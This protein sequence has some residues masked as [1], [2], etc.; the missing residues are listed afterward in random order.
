MI[1][2]PRLPHILNIANGFIDRPH[3]ITAKTADETSYKYTRR[4]SLAVVM[5]LHMGHSFVAPRQRSQHARQHVCQQPVLT[6]GSVYA[7]RQIRHCVE[8]AD[9]PCDSYSHRLRQDF[10]W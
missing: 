2:P 5:R 10:F 7:S 8:P 3:T 9:D 6:V 4:S 1:I